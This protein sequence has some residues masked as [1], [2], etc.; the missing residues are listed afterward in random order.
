VAHELHR[1]GSGLARAL[2]TALH[3]ARQGAEVAAG[4][5]RNR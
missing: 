1:L 3:S 2:R 4:R 5:M